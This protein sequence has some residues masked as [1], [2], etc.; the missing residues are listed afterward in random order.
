MEVMLKKIY[1]SLIVS[2]LLVHQQGIS[3]TAYVVNYGDNTIALCPVNPD[4][5]LAP[6]S[7][8]VNPNNSLNAPA[9]IVFNSEGTLAFITNY[10]STPATIT[11][12]RLNSDGTFSNYCFATDGGGTFDEPNGITINAA[13]TVL[14]IANGGASTPGSV[15][16]C[17][18]GSCG[19][20][21]CTR[22]E[23]IIP[24]DSN[25][26]NGVALNP[27]NT[28]AYV[29][30]YYEPTNTTETKIVTICPVDSITGLLDIASCFSGDGDGSLPTTLVGPIDIK[31]NASNTFAYISDNQ[32]SGPSS[33]ALTIC[34]IDAV[35]FTLINCAD[36]NMA[37]ASLDGAAGIFLTP[38]NLY[39]ASDNNESW[40]TKCDLI[41]GGAQV[42]NCVNM[43]DPNFNAAN[44]ISIL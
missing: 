36:Q 6:C 33:N 28:L 29:T 37:P 13:G 41:S 9:N 44:D 27:S 40:I 31:I 8:G 16:V 30:V 4:G 20:D 34:E 23:P 38:T 14:Y 42:D 35:N 7:A 39:I 15:T 11:I 24:L 21:S 43:F 1:F 12:C 2:L 18:L 26:T 32:S 17:R 19:I 10:T 3:Q 5:T 22:Q 25:G